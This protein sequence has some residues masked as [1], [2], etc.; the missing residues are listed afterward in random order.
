MKL[1]INMPPP[2]LT[3]ISKRGGLFPSFRGLP[4]SCW[5]HI[6]PQLMLGLIRSLCE[7]MR[8]GEGK[9]GKYVRYACQHQHTLANV[10]SA[11]LLGVGREHESERAFWLRPFVGDVLF[12]ESFSPCALCAVKIHQ[13]NLL[14]EM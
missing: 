14:R 7:T 9:K 4:R 2:L 12:R 5:P 10:V 3:N 11:C 13:Y 8:M 1:D 6:F